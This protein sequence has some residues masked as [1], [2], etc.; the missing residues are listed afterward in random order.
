MNY[1]TELKKYRSTSKEYQRLWRQRRRQDAEFYAKELERSRQWRENNTDRIKEQKRKYF[2]ETKEKFRDARNLRAREVTKRNVRWERE[3]TKL[4]VEEAKDLCKRMEKLTGE[5]WEVDH[6]LPRMGKKVSGF[7]LW[8][9]LQ[10]LPK[11]LNH[12]KYNKHET[13]W[14]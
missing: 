3:L 11:R 1:E 4:A 10:V 8:R 2:Q 7:H 14:T 13:D 12:Q 5:A 9:N 6:V